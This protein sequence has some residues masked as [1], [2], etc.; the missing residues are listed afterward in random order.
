MEVVARP[1]KK[2]RKKKRKKKQKVPA[3]TCVTANAY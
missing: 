2:K 1:V 3:G